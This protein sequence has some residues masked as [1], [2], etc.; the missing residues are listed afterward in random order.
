MRKGRE[1][2]MKR[3]AFYIVASIAAYLFAGFPTALAQEGEGPDGGFSAYSVARVKVLDG[4]V[5]VRPSDGG[6]WEEFPSNSPIPPR[7]RVSVPEGSEAELQF[8]GGQFVLLTSG[9]DLEIRDLQEGISDFRLRAGE[10]RFDLP[11][12]EFAPV[13]VRMP[14]G[15]VAR[16]PEPGRQWLT[17][18][19]DGETRLVV[20]RGQAVVALEGEEYPL[21]AGEEAVIGLGITVGQ[22]RGGEVD[23]ASAPPPEEP[24]G[25]TPPAVV[26]ELSEYGE[27]VDVPEYGY[28]WRPRV[29][30]GWSPYVYG[31]WVWIFPYGWTWVS[32]E[33]WGWYPY[34]TGYWLTDPVF[35]WIWTPYNSFVSVNFVFGSHRYR[36][37]N[38][39]F[40]PATV[41]FIPEGRN[42][43][44]VP[45]RPGERF[46]PAE[47]RRGDARLSRWNRPLDSGR[48]FV[49][50]GPDRREWRDYRAVRAERQAEIRKIRAAQPRP[51]TRT[52]R[53]ERRTVRPP[54]RQPATRPALK[55]GRGKG[56]ARE[57]APRQGKVERQAP[58][59][60]V[61]TARPPVREK[62]RE[63]ASRAVP[64]PGRVERQGPVRSFP[65]DRPPVRERVREH[66]SRAVPP[67]G[68]VQRQAPLRSFP[69]DRPPVRERVREPA[70]RA[71]PPPGRVERQGPVR[72]VPPARGAA[73]ATRSQES[74]GDRGGDAA[75]RGGDRGGDRSGGRGYDR[76]VDRGGGG[77][78]R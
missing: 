66:S 78:W 50:G 60:S 69:A 72:S 31:R 35:G 16:F 74:R 27:W 29:A 36:H 56:S 7:S 62:V 71:L 61:P 10:I 68:R 63:P 6:D 8:H 28:A 55:E 34:R 33:P 41:R 65:A 1:R 19:E 12:D 13:T 5:W 54:V 47:F 45:L 48:V 53:P 23:T 57:T 39:F 75:G 4:T 46:R 11:P 64:P 37:H 26:N 30:V 59:R 18:T 25:D 22:Y 51:D 14:G 43:R 20:R 67:P 15:A 76:G 2:A 9:T 38:V 42:V 73:P 70:S 77:R 58:L 21:R 40:R 52:L 24:L 3:A 49:R 17:V 32:Y 44:W